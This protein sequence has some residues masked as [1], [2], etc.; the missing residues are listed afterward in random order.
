MNGKFYFMNQNKYF[1]ILIEIK[2]FYKVNK[3]KISIK[4]LL[5]NSIYIMI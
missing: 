4:F 3:I 1:Q 5:K 2:Y